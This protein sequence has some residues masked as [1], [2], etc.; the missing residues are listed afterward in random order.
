MKLWTCYA[1]LYERICNPDE[2]LEQ[3]GS[4][5]SCLENTTGR[6]AEGKEVEAYDCISAVTIVAQ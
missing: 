4:S 2:L 5:R 3:Q 1:C 6:D